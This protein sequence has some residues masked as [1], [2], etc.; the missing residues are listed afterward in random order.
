MQ[1]RAVKKDLD[2]CCLTVSLGEKM[3]YAIY[4][5]SIADI[6]GAKFNEIFKALNRQ[7]QWLS[8]RHVIDNG[9]DLIHID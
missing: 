1:E 5:R 6:T 7:C 4:I 9:F 3:N 2:R 8:I